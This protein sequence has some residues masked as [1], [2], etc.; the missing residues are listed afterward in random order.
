MKKQF[1]K[2][3]TKV[4]TQFGIQT[5]QIQFETLLSFIKRGGEIQTKKA[6]VAVLQKVSLKEETFL[7]AA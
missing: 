6:K 2:R 4:R 5:R 3:N 7:H 1:I